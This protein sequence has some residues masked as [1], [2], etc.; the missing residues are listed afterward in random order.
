M[1]EMC[2]F[3]IRNYKQCQ[4]DPKH[5]FKEVLKCAETGERDNNEACLEEYWEDLKNVAKT[6]T[7]IVC[8]VC[9]D[10]IYIPQGDAANCNYTP[11]EI[12]E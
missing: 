7:S 4:E 11:L 12:V 3:N 10:L 8:P 5:T 9:N 2:S 1:I 6:T